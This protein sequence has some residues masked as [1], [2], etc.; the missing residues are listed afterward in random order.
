MKYFAKQI[1]RNDFSVIGENT[2]LF[3]LVEENRTWYPTQIKAEK[4]LTKVKMKIE[5]EII[6]FENK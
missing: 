6:E 3:I 4:Y 1:Q 5:N 2:G